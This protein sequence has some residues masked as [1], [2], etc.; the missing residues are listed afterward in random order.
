[1]NS[2]FYWPLM[3][4]AITTEDR[5]DLIEFLSNENNRLTNGVKVV[6]FEQLWSNW[7]GVK[8]SV[9]VNSGASAHDLTLLALKELHGIGEVI[10]PPLTW[11]SDVASIINAGLKPIFVDIDLDTLAISAEKI[12]NA[13]NKK[14]KAV[15]LT[16]ILGLNGLNNK[17]IEVIDNSN[18]ILIEDACESHGAKFNGKNV[19]TFGVVSNFS[20]YYAHHMTTIEGGAISTSNEEWRDALVMMRSHGLVRESKNVRIKSNYQKKYPELNPE[21]T[22]AYAS[23]NMRP[24]ELNAVLGIS[25]LKRIDSN[26]RIR[27][28]NFDYFLSE[29]DSNQYKTDFETEGNSNYALI[30]ILRNPD[31]N[32]KNYIEAELKKNKIEFRKGLAGGGNQLRQPYLINKYGQFDLDKFPNVE[33]VHSFSWYVGN[34]PG[35][36]REKIDRLL[37][38]LN[39]AK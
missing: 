25:Q 27:K 35:L 5:T 24:T 12:Q 30:I 38:I 26:I 33:H 8:Y 31:I 16:H 36:A 13:L 6:E 22:F 29:L 19:G 3:H 17:I 37:E 15:F 11:V 18:A 21:F 28:D 32:K 34:Y 20:F 2:D 10:V 39:R 9:M 7:L 1:M 23:H 14:T 4:D